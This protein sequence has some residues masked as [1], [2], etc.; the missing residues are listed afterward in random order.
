M[1]I[2]AFVALVVIG[3]VD[4]RERLVHGAAAL[5]GLLVGHGVVVVWRGINTLPGVAMTWL[6]AAALL[7]AWM[8]LHR[9]APRWRIAIAVVISV[10]PGFFALDETRVGAVV[11]WPILAWLVAT[12][13]KRMPRPTSNAAAAVLTGSQVALRRCLCGRATP[14][15]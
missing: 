12:S 3:W 8:W 2:V 13:F 1:G 14:R 7:V 10:L 5:V 11:V 4:G 15:S 9:V 6:G